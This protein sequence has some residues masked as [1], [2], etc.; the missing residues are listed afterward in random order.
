MGAGEALQDAP[1]F[2]QVKGK[3]WLTKLGIVSS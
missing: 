3:V 1:N 2:P